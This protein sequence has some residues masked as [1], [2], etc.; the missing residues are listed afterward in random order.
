M[1]PCLQ[2][3]FLPPKQQQA[4]TSIMLTVKLRCSVIV[5]SIA[6]RRAMKIIENAPDGYERPRFVS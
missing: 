3:R 2:K 5:I 4:N 1:F 6:D